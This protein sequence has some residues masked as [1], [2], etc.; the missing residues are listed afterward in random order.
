[1]RGEIS[2]SQ[3]QKWCHEADDGIPVLIT[4]GQAMHVWLLWHTGLLMFFQPQCLR[5]SASSGKI[6][7]NVMFVGELWPRAICKAAKLR[8]EDG[9]WKVALVRLLLRML[10]WWTDTPRLFTYLRRGCGVP[11]VLFLAN[12]DADMTA[13]RSYSD[14]AAIQTDFPRKFSTK[15]G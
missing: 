13:C 10:K 3:I 4:F 6:V 9:N 8:E 2:S 5:S 15:S 14:V 11:V 12:T 7:F 1:M